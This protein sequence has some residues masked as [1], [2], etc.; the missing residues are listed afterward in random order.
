MKV[1]NTIFPSSKLDDVY[2]KDISGGGMPYL[3]K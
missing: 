1:I 2:N 3:I